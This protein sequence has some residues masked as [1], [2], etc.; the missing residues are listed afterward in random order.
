MNPEFY[1]TNR[2]VH[3]ECWFTLFT[4]Q[5]HI[6][7]KKS[8]RQT[9]HNLVLWSDLCHPWLS[10]P[11]AGIVVVACLGNRKRRFRH[12]DRRLWSD[13][14]QSHRQLLVIRPVRPTN[15]NN[16]LEDSSTLFSCYVL[17]FFPVKDVVNKRKTKLKTERKYKSLKNKA[18]KKKK[19]TKKKK[20]KM[21]IKRKG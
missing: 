17:F 10:I 1:S 3:R 11:A 2:I 9:R 18:E 16:S 19:K 20:S 6:D 7:N 4:I 12:W 5:R 14:Y 8:K 15:K 13:S 21:T